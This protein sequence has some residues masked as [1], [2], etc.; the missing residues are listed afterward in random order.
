MADDAIFVALS[1]AI[2]AAGV[3]GLNKTH[4][5]GFASWM[6]GLPTCIMTRLLVFD[7]GFKKL[8]SSWLVALGVLFYLI[9]SV[10]ESTWVDPG[11]YSVAVVLISFGVG[12]GVLS[13]SES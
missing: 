8:A 7:G 13:E 9:W 5:G 1:V 4:E 10:N 2:L 12:I 11:V 3:L 6:S